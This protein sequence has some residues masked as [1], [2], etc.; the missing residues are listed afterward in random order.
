RHLLFM[1]EKVKQDPLSPKMLAVNGKDVM[2]IAKI[3]A[4]PKVGQVLAILLEEILE[5]PDKNEKKYLEK[6]ILELIKL[7]DKELE[8]LTGGAKE[9]KE[10]FESGIEEEM[11]RRFYV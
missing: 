8:K 6:R 11:K 5:K 3:E 9:R 7:K 2:E 10:E 1:V 4:G